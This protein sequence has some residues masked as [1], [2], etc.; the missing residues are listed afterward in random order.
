MND[1]STIITLV[2]GIVTYIFGELSKKFNWVEKEFIIIQ[3]II[4]GVLS[5]TLYYIFIDGSSV[6]NAIVVV[7]GA[8]GAAGVYD[9]TRLPKKV[10]ENEEKGEKK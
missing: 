9:L 8:L 5:A 1:L 10:N 6:K 2:V 7:F 4:I 3:D